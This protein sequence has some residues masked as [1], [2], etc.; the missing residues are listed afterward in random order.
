MKAGTLLCTAA[1]LT[2]L[3]ACTSLV[4]PEVTK[5][6]VEVQHDV[7]IR[8]RDGVKLAANISRPAADGRYPVILVRTPYGKDNGEDDDG[9][10]HARRGYV[11]IIQDCRGTGESE[12]EWNPGHNERRDGLDTLDW[13]LEQPWCN[14]T[15][16]TAGGSY[17]GFTQWAVAADAGERI[18][19]MFTVVPLVDWYK[20][21]TY[22]DGALSLALMMGWGSGMIRPKEGEGAGIEDEVDWERAWRYLPLATWDDVLGVKVPFLRDWVAHPSFDSYWAK[23]RVIDRMDEVAAPNIT[24]T[25]WYDIFVNGAF[26]TVGAVARTAESQ[27]ARNHQYLVVGPWGHGINYVGGDLEFGDESEI[28]LREIEDWWFDYW[29]KGQDAGV[30]E[31][32]HVRIFV[33]GRNEWRDEEEWPLARTEFTPYYV[34]SEG[35]ANSLNGDGTLSTEKPGRER[36]DRYI[37]DPN[38]PVPTVGGCNMVI[39]G[40]P[41]DQRQVEEREDVLVFTSD[42]LKEEVEVTGPV[43]AVLWASSSAPD[44]DWTAK[45]VDVH[46][47]GRAFNLCDGIVRARYRESS[48]DPTLIEPGKVYRYEIDV[49]VTSNVFL[50]GHRIRVEISSSNFPRFDR[51]P[52]TGHRFGAD[53]E[54]REATQTVYHD[55]E[56]PSH[57]LL[58]IIPNSS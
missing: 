16:G 41:H 39:P 32:P 31:W 47:D 49:W 1:L 8:M 19:S 48:T 2:L 6:E 38:N 15:I 20:D 51:N 25:G 37:Y 53:A 14:G 27:R 23:M 12:G 3:S 36:A 50:P 35:S 17:L 4:E 24:V 52:S 5:F 9:R 44:T 42:V 34:H 18:K 7:Y 45:L 10:Y 40:G 13:A 28:D 26:E 55:A 43:K 54:L 29:L 22:K 33:M 21:G 46:P 56:R 30:E 58:P 11:F 57:I